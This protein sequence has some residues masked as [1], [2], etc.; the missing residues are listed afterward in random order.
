MFLVPFWADKFTELTGVFATVPLAM[1]VITFPSE[2]KV[3]EIPTA[4]EVLTFVSEV[5]VL[6]VTMATGVLGLVTMETGFFAFPPSN[7]RAI[8]GETIE[9]I[10]LDEVK[11]LR[12]VSG[13]SG[14]LLKL[15]LF[16]AEIFSVVRVPS[17]MAGTFSLMDGRTAAPS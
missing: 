12:A 2:V 3:F 10:T 6:A 7:C 11:L 14:A 16:D 1:G 13:M 8:A 9:L 17:F 5:G 15:D 4:S